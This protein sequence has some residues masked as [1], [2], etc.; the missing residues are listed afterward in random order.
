MLSHPVV[1][2]WL[3]VEASGR[4]PTK[5]PVQCNTGNVFETYPSKGHGQAVAVTFHVKLCREA[6]KQG[7]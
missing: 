4:E 2:H 5:H 1:A 6:V 7:S 3:F